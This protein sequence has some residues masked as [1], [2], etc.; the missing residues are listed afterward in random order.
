MESGPKKALVLVGI[1]SQGSPK[2]AGKDYPSLFMDV[3]KETDWIFKTMEKLEG[4]K[5]NKTVSESD[6]VERA[7]AS[8]SINWR[9]S[10]TLLV[11]L[12]IFHLI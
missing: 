5:D 7:H 4:T 1:L 9:F 10:L 8:R 6:V 2:C 3:R 12:T 11:I